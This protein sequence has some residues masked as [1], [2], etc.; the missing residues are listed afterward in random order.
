[1][2]PGVAANYGFV[3]DL[4]KIILDASLLSFWQ[5][6]LSIC[7]YLANNMDTW[8]NAFLKRNIF[9]HKSQIKQQVCVFVKPILYLSFV[10]ISHILTHGR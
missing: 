7:I 1:M 2:E 3:P 4:K 10:T 8:E 6:I 5:L 9:K